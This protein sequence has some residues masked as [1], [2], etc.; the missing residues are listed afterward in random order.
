MGGRANPEIA[1]SLLAIQLTPTEHKLLYELATNAGKVLL[2][3]DLLARVWGPEY[4]DEVDYWWTYVRYLRNKIDRDFSEPL[5][6]TVRGVGYTLK[7]S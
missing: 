4:R 7:A 6:K 5:I 1:A 3:S 2:Y